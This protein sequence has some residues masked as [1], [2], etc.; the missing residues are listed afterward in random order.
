M[1]GGRTAVREGRRVKGMVDEVD[2]R[3]LNQTCFFLV[4]LTFIHVTNKKQ[5]LRWEIKILTKK[6]GKTYPYVTTVNG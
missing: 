3:N 2:C 5:R 1:T 4:Y 6:C